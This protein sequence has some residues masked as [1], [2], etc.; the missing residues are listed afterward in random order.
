MPPNH[1]QHHACLRLFSSSSG[2]QGGARPTSDDALRAIQEQERQGKPTVI[3]DPTKSRFHIPWGDPEFYDT[4]KL[5]N[6]L[7]RVFDICHGCRRCF[8]LCNSFP[9]L[10]Q[11]IDE[12]A[13]GQ[14]EKLPSSRFKEVVDDCTLCDMCYLVKCPYVPP[15]PLEVDFPHLMLRYRA[16]ENQAQNVSAAHIQGTSPTVDS[17]HRHEIFPVDEGIDRQLTLQ[18]LPIGE[19]QL[20][21]TDRNGLL[22]S[23]A[24]SVANWALSEKNQ[25]TR[26]VAE[27]VVNVHRDAALPKFV[28][29]SK[30]FT[31]AAVAEPL[32]PNPNAPAFASKRKVVLYS[33]CLV[34]WNE[35]DI[36]HAA[37]QVLIHQGVHV[38]VCYP[39]C[40]GMPFFEA[41]Q[42]GDVAQRA[43]DICDSLLRYVRDGYSVIS[44]TPSCTIMLKEK[45]PLL[46]PEDRGV[47][48]VQ[49]A[50]FDIAEYVMD[51]ARKEGINTEGLRPL[52][53]H[54]ALHQACHSK[55][56]NVGFKAHDM[57]KLI[58]SAD[59]HVID[60]CSGHG[61]SWGCKK[62][63][64]ATALKVGKPAARQ[65]VRIVES[66]ASSQQNSQSDS[67]LPVVS[68]ECMLAGQ[69][70][71]QGMQ[72]LSETVAAKV[73]RSVHPIELL[74][75]AYGF[76]ERTRSTSE[77][78]RV[79]SL[80]G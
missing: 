77:S 64:H 25:V 21:H 68:S 44:L 12:D 72:H 49:A 41:G 78:N 24:P 40:C 5:D 61:G 73:E 3:K 59:L 70:I 55:A 32:S 38:E 52:K 57:L 33:T 26:A 18:P 20:L 53:S 30:T 7:R 39:E 45:W 13:D 19:K 6:E 54:V 14:V 28:G 80:S 76:S 75:S 2:K 74:A 35:P 56:Q 34:N 9:R 17:P 22:A 71:L 60:K 46:L 10:F 4:T 79:E 47:G 69:H 48:E 63:C 31:K 65:A 16:V 1:T 67:P 23:M 15:H 36:G 42:L 43:K 51:I 29:R 11:M 27:H 8:N 62:Q 66:Q 37:R 58:P 50:T